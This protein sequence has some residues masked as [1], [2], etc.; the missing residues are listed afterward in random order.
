MGE[1]KIIVL[2]YV[3]TR[4]L[5]VRGWGEYKISALGYVVSRTSSNPLN[6]SRGECKL[7]EY[8]LG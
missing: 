4:A 3:V 7:G 2:G 6:S 8:Q 5:K 1:Y